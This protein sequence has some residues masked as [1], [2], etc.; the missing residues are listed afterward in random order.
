VFSGKQEKSDV[1][2][3]GGGV[4]GMSLARELKK[5][6]AGTV[7]LLE[8][9]RLGQE[10]SFAAAGML[11]PQCE[12]EKQDAFFEFCYEGRGLYENFAAELED[13]SGID[14]ALETSGILS[15]SFDD[16]NSKKLDQI[17]NWQNAAGFEVEKLGRNEI[18]ALEPNLSRELYDGLFFPRDAQVDN[19]LLAEALAKSI[20]ND[21]VVVHEGA[22]VERLLTKNG[23][24]SGAETSDGTFYSP[25]VVLATGA[26]TSLI[27][28]GDST[29]PL[30]EV[31][32]VRGQMISFVGPEKLFTH[33]IN[34]CEGYLVPRAGDKIL[35]GATVEDTGFDKVVTAE[36]LEYLIKYAYSI[37]PGLREAKMTEKWAGL[38]PR[39]TDDLP[40]LGK[41][42]DLQGL[43]I[44]TAHFRNGILLAPL[45]AKVMAEQILEGRTST[46]LEIFSPNRFTRIATANLG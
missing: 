42:K 37:A 25:V 33:V 45:T 41:Y 11:A 2:I 30:V 16:E 15:I 23:R 19:R 39:A 44:A 34:T 1:L 7:T 12:A 14:V 38:R 9:G 18:L 10:A 3:I 27:K 21:G 4:I 20:K 29:M 22:K 24:I 31:A 6:G 17:Y 35:V 13:E 8:R 43:F 46:Y 40:V 28:C 32:P 36:G 5:K 26:W